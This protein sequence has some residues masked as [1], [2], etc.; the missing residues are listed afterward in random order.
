MQRRTTARATTRKKYTVDA[1]EGV[2]E[3]E[4][5]DSESGELLDEDEGENHDLR[6]VPKLPRKP[7]DIPKNP[8]VEEARRRWANDLTLP[9][10]CENPDGLGGFHNSLH[11]DDKARLDADDNWLWYTNGGGKEAFT[12][13]QQ[14]TSLTDVEV[15]GYRSPDA[16]I[17]FVMGPYTDQKLFGLTVGQSVPLVDAWTGPTS[18]VPD[19][20]QH[21]RPGF[22]LNLGTVRCLE[23]VPGQ[24]GK[25]Q[26]LT[27]TA[28]RIPDTKADQGD[29][30]D[31][32]KPTGQSSICMWSFQAD[33]AG[34]VDT[35]VRP[36]L[37]LV[38]CTAWGAITS[39]KWCPVP[40][41]EPT[42]LGLLAL[43]AG[44]GALRVL[45]VPLSSRDATHM[46]VRRV[47]IE[48]RPNGTLCVCVAWICPTRLAAG[49]ADGTLLI[50]DLEEALSAS[51]YRGLSIPVST[52]EITSI[53]SCAPSHPHMLLAS[54]ADGS[55]DLV[56]TGNISSL[57]TPLTGVPFPTML[58]RP[59]LLWHNYSQRA[60][61]TDDN[62]EVFARQLRKGSHKVAVSK[63]R[64]IITAI[65]EST[66][67]P[68]L[69][70][71]TAGGEVHVTNP[72][73]KAVNP[74]GDIWQ[75]TWFVHEWRRA[76]AKEKDVA[77]N[78]AMALTDEDG[79]GTAGRNGLSR[80]LEGFKP[81]RLRPDVR[82]EVSVTAG[83]SP[84]VIYE[85]KTA[86][87]A[88]AWNSN[89]QC[90]GWA[91]AAMADGL[92]RVEDIAV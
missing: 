40:C 53:T 6:S 48:S 86:I 75:Q 27:T 24:R 4:E 87:T 69:L 65:A 90:A 89:V 77:D 57:V 36:E 46:L 51:E 59:L 29:T 64:S 42:T 22:M 5:A 25:V 11:Q 91:A 63:A 32:S 41:P 31:P 66:H 84:Y 56:D 74:K 47:L 61:T 76:T 23:W 21:S 79:D 70:T 12:L 43:I 35:T 19:S 45:D 13:Q 9:S 16:A 7:R 44:D 18:N 58:S 72:I 54:S 30:S 52:S 71:G 14:L 83:S 33:D 49:C 67:H 39:L 34:Y 8:S 88:L 15:E 3:L 1:F 38:L 20:V 10:R 28:G 80:L 85:E 50:F 37:A 55:L 82:G 62:C 73:I 78:D 17:R 2:P 60:F 81:E 92:V 68:C 26:Y